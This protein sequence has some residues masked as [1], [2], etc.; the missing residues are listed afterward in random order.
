MAGCAASAPWNVPREAR[1]RVPGVQGARRP[2][3]GPAGVMLA[4]AAGIGRLARAGVLLRLR[5]IR[6]L[7]REPQ[8]QGAADPPGHED[9][10]AHMVEQRRGARRV[11]Y[12]DQQGG[13]KAGGD[14]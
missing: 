11:E 7:A 1:M 14:P 6:A 10:I 5:R 2:D 8:P 12:I 13:G 3:S 9:G 4:R